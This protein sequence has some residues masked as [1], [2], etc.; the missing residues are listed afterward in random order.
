M[1]VLQD[2]A[3]HPLAQDFLTF[4][5]GA[6]ISI[7]LGGFIGL[8]VFLHVASQIL[9]KNPNEPPM[10]FSWF[11]IIGSTVTYGMDP[12]TFFKENRAKV[13]GYSSPL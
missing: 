8:S 6:Q 13:G 5:L 9:F 1:G 11:P 7:I 2:M 12:P 3:A 4:G 10:V